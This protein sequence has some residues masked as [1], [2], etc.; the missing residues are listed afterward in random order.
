MFP[1][2]IASGDGN[3]IKVGRIEECD[4]RFEEAVVERVPVQIV[5]QSQPDA[6]RTKS[7]GFS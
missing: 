3:L 4:H 6:V 7:R 5:F 2:L 1:H